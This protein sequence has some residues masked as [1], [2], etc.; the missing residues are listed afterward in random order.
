[1]RKNLL[2]TTALVLA[3]GFAGG[4]VA[5]DKISLSLEGYYTFFG[6]VA[7]QD[8]GTGEPG[9][10]LREHGVARESEVGFIGETTLDNGIT[11]GVDVQLQGET[12]GDQIDESYIFFEGAFG[13]IQLGSE[14]PAS[15]EMFYGAPTPIAE[16]GVNSPTF[17]HAAAGANAVGSS[18]TFVN[19]TS[20]S[21]KI[22]Y[23]T[24]RFHGFQLGVSYTPDNTEELGF[25]LRPENTPAGAT[26]QQSEVF[27]GA[28]N[29]VGDIGDVALGVY[30]GY[31]TA[32]LEGAAAGT[33]PLVGFEDQEMWGFGGSFEYMGFTFGASYR[34]T[35]QGLSGSNTDRW[36][37]NVGL[38]YAWG[39]WSFGA[40]YAHAEVEVGAGAGEDEMDQFEIGFTYNLGPGVDIA[41]GIQ[42]VDFDSDTGGA[43]AEND[44]VIGLLG[45]VISF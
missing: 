10:G 43:A 20:D 5:A 21:D 22:T 45:T 14:D 44:A 26:P 37:G 7:D 29:W 1:M 38:T 13:R 34:W 15:D 19:L 11:V 36:D 39:D 42:V 24:P 16:N 3:M 33:G 25:A 31:S 2:G 9:A 27:E 8:D 40:A 35:D 32:D 23:F 12:V 41:G 28:I 6:V 18:G 17:F 4:A 30:V